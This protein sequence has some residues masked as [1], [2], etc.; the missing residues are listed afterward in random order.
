MYINYHYKKENNSYVTIKIYYYTV[1]IH[2]Y[3][4]IMNR[5]KILSLIN[6]QITI[7]FNFKTL[8]DLIVSTIILDV[9]KFTKQNI[10]NVR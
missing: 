10:Q 8:F 1:V 7:L 5:S 4:Y 9:N 2:I 3:I 6:I